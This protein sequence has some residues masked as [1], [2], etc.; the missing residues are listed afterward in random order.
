MMLGLEQLTFTLRLT[1]IVLPVAL[2]FLV[3]GLLNSRRHPQLLTSRQDFVL[4][5]TILSPLVLVPALGMLEGFWGVGVAAMLLGGLGLLLLTDHRGGQWVV[6]NLPPDQ[7]VGVMERC[8]ARLNTTATRTETGLEFTESSDAN[9]GDAPSRVTLEIRP[10][11]LLR[12]VSLRLRNASPHLTRRFRDELSRHLV[13]MET[14]TTTMAMALLI[15]ATTMMIAPLTLVVQKAPELV[16]LL[17][18]VGH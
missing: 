2:Y 1:A 7:A 18:D 4:L 16:R 11:P 9:H 17:T 8:L 6:Y 12:N 14:P 15:T 5:M 3:L 13:A 10:F